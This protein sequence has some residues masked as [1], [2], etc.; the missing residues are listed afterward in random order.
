MFKGFYNL[1]SG[2]LS[3]SRN[4]DVVAN[5][6]SN[7]STAGYKADR[8]V[9]STFQEVLLSRVG[10]KDKSNPAELGTISYILAPSELM[11]D[12]SQGAQEETGLPLDFCILGEGY[13]AVEG[14][15]G[16]VYTR[17]GA[18]MLDDQ[19][20]LALPAQGR[21]L[22]SNGQP[23]F[24]GT[25][26]FTCDS[27]GNLKSAAGENLGQLG[28]FRF[29]EDNQ[30]AKTGAGM[31]TTGAQPVGTQGVVAWKALERANVDLMGQITQMMSCQRAL[32]SA[33]QLSKMYDQI[34]SKATND[35]GRL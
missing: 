2:M 28:I 34:M 30:M 25:D 3:Q 18:L 15:Q 4:I 6:M 16:R 32:Q 10:N 31:F 33:A 9:D 26:Q 35:V 13:F 19:G 5:N 22:G 8:Y 14:Q 1:T 24:L 11:T 7:F 23:I 12:Y 21:V 29:G 27:V 20:Y 17:N